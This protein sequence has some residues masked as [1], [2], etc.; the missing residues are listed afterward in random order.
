MIQANQIENVLQEVIQK[1]AEKLEIPG[2]EL[3]LLVRN[4]QG[5]GE[6]HWYHGPKYVEPYNLEELAAEIV[7]SLLKG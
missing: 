4:H 6:M 2:D 5:K 7:E 3:Y 1:K